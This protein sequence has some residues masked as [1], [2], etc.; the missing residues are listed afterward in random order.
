MV[1]GIPKEIKTHEYRVAITPYGVRELVSRGHRV[2]CQSTLGE[3]SG[4]SDEMYISSGAEIYQRSNC[5]KNQN[6]S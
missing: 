5:L 4:F 1:I 6:L 2:L 3:D